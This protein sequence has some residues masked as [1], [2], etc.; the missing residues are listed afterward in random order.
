MAGERSRFE[1]SGESL[2]VVPEEVR[3]FVCDRVQ[4]VEGL[5]VLRRTASHPSR[6]WPPSELALDLYLSQDSVEEAIDV[7]VESGLLT[8]GPDGRCSYRPGS[9]RFDEIV[10][11]ALHVYHEHPSA[12]VQCLTDRAMNRM[13]VSLIRLTERLLDRARS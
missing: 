1:D 5:E 2:S 4:S 10:Q 6:S 3:L 12:I 9:E 7:L 13:R 8:K 11:R